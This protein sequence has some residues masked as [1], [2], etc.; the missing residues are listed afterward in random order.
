MKL[1][2]TRYLNFSIAFLLLVVFTNCQEEETSDI[3][4]QEQPVIGLRFNE[5]SFEELFTQPSFKK[6]FL[7]TMDVKSELSKLTKANKED[8]LYKCTIDSSR[9]KEIK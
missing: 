3:A 2:I 5:S 8:N 4:E 9:I 6:G 7:E 1:Q